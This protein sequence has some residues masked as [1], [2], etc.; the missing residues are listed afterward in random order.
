MEYNKI[1][2]LLDAYFEGNTSLAEEQQLRTYFASEQVADTLLPYKALFVSFS[3]AAAEVSTSRIELPEVS[4]TNNRWWLS[5]A[6]TVVVLIGVAGFIHSSN[7]L[8]SEEEEALAALY[9]SKEAMLLLSQNLNKGAQ[10]LL[11]L[12][13]FTESKKRI[14]K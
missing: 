6:A 10:T 1:Q 8:S 7:S 5:I 13:Q 11:L 12:D 2:S 3:E 4:K 14:L 9:Q